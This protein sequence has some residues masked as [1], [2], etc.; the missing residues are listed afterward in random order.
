MTLGITHDDS[1]VVRSARERVGVVDLPRRVRQVRDGDPER[2]LDLGA[3]CDRRR[4]AHVVD[5]RRD[6]EPGGLARV[7]PLQVVEA[8]EQLG[9][10]EVDAH[11]LEGLALGCVPQT[12]VRALDAAAGKR[13]VPRP[14]VACAPCPFDQQHLG[15]GCGWPQHHR[16][17]RVANP[18]LVDEAGLVGGEGSAN[19]R[20]IEHGAEDSPA[21]TPGRR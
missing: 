12:L 20:Q 16:H 4:I 11:L 3:R 21:S 10:R 7:A 14:R 5:E 9:A 18:F 19:A 6:D 15:C 13:H 1:G 17:G 2:D 8:P